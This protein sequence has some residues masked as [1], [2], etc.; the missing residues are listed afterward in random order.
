MSLAIRNGARSNQRV[1]EQEDKC[2]FHVFDVRQLLNRRVVNNSAIFLLA[3]IRAIVINEVNVN[4]M[5]ARSEFQN[6]HA[7]FGIF[8][9]FIRL[10]GFVRSSLSPQR[11]CG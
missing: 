3:I 11:A 6:S 1:A 5:G 9:P 10:S 2:S 7:P 8:S 4:S